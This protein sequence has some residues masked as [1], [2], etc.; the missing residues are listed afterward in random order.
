[1]QAQKKVVILL[2][3]RAMM[4]VRLLAEPAKRKDDIDGDIIK[5][6]TGRKAFKPKGSKAH[7]TARS[8]GKAYVEKFLL[9][10]PAAPDREA[11]K[12][13]MAEKCHKYN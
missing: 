6:R 11:S 5:T 1:M 12:V 9:I 3:K 8:K 13:L 2:P 10:M 7:Y 4:K